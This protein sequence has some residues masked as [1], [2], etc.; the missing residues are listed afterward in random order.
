MV[1]CQRETGIPFCGECKTLIS[2]SVS[3]VDK[4]NLSR[5]DL[6]QYVSR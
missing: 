4:T 2:Q 3:Y 6:I 5:L 1:G